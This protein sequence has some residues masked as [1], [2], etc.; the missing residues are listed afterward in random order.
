MDSSSKTPEGLTGP[1]LK[2]KGCLEI[3][4]Y[5]LEKIIDWVRSFFLTIGLFT[6]YGPKRLITT[7]STKVALVW[8]CSLR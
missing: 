1:R 8:T 3:T 7:V 2:K 5:Y 4:V 6:P